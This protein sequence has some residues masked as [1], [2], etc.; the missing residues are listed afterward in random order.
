MSKKKKQSKKNKK[1]D[2]SEEVLDSFVRSMLTP[3]VIVHLLKNKDFVKATIAETR[4]AKKDPSDIKG[5]GD[6]YKLPADQVS[7]GLDDVEQMLTKMLGD[8]SDEV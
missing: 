2:V 5:L 6:K 7:D 3:E 8:V 1:D 4:K